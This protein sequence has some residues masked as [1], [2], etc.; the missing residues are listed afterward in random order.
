MKKNVYINKFKSRLFNKLFTEDFIR[1]VYKGILEREPDPEGFQAYK[2]SLTNPSNVDSL[3][4]QKLESMISE[5]VNSAEFRQINSTK[6]GSRVENIDLN[7]GIKRIPST[8]H[9]SECQFIQ[10]LARKLP[11]NS[12]VVETGTGAGRVSCVIALAI[13]GKHSTLYTVDNY[14]QL[15]KY[16]GY[17]DWT[18]RSA[19]ESAASLNV[20]GHIQFIEGNSAEVGKTFDKPI[21]MLY[22]DGTHRYAEVCREI[23]AWYPH[24][25]PGGII[26]GH[27]FDPNCD[28]GRNV[29]KAI[30]DILLINP[31]RPLNVRERVWWME[32]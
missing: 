21:D 6:L 7:D 2:K 13:A 24:V 18:P 29:I 15:G 9:L 14:S 30:F 20:D 31:D 26:A 32:K 17:G 3:L 10:E 16:G 28:D 27:D 1:W 4:T 22:L 23:D 8:T 25:N 5:F 19:K 12:I 11:K